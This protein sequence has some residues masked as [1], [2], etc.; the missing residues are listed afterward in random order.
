MKCRISRWATQV[1][2]FKFKS[3]EASL[4]HYSGKVAINTHVLTNVMDLIKSKIAAHA[5]DYI[6]TLPDL[7]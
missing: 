2:F 6:Q 3:N 7:N 4:K 5:I 1:L